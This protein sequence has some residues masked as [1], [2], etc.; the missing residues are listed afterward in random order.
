MLRQRLSAILQRYVQ[1]GA[2]RIDDMDMAANQMVELCKSDLFSRRLCGVSDGVS[3][4]DIRRVSDAAV[5]MFLAR[6]GAI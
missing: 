2:L 5:E 4:E 6:Y 1:R 3:E